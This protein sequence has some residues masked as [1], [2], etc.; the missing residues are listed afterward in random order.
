MKFRVTKGT[1]TGKEATRGGWG[2]EKGEWKEPASIGPLKWW[3]DMVAIEG[4]IACRADH[5]CL[6][7]DVSTTAKKRWGGC[8]VQDLDSMELRPFA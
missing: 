1:C 7:W 5:P 8:R 4:K 6:H 3:Y 2:K